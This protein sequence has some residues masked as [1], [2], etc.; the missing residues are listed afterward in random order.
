MATSFRQ[1]CI[2]ILLAF[3][4]AYVLGINHKRAAAGDRRK[5]RHHDTC[6]YICFHVHDMPAKAI[7]ASDAK[8]PFNVDR[9]YRRW[10]PTTARQ[11]KYRSWRRA[12][13]GFPGKICARNV[14]S[15]F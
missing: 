4:P 3:T 8:R 1:L 10:C 2:S 7:G 6:A 13:V 15:R 14:L 5:A 9:H 12:S 11:A